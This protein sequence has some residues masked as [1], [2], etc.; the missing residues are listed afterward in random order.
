MVLAWWRMGHRGCVRGYRR[1]RADKEIKAS[2]LLTLGLSAY[3]SADIGM[4]PHHCSY[5]SWLAPT[6]PGHIKK[7]PK[8]GALSFMLEKFP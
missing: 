2:L 6:P 8:S 1:G 5:F 3:S 7:I 4:G